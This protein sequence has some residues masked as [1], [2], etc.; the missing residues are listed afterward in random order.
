MH[1]SSTKLYLH[2]SFVFPKM[3]ISVNLACIP[4]M[5][6]LYL[7]SS[8]PPSLI[9]LLWS[10]PFDP[11]LT[12]CI[13]SSI[14]CILHPCIHCKILYPSSDLSFYHSILIY[15][16]LFPSLSMPLSIFIHHLF[17]SSSLSIS[18]YLASYICNSIFLDIY[19]LSW[20]SY[21]LSM[22]CVYPSTLSSSIHLI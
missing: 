5:N 4:T 1:Y 15:V 16:H 19:F 21:S 8:L 13:S 12:S 2:A 22:H 18:I 14:W 10:S 7:F 17:L 3:F 9:W 6:I 20:T 11:S